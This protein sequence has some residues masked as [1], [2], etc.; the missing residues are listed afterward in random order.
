MQVFVALLQKGGDLCK[1]LQHHLRKDCDLCK[2][3]QHDLRKD[4]DLCKY[5]QHDLRKD[6]DLCKYLQHDLRKDGDL[7]KYLQHDLR[8]DGDLCNY[9]QHDFQKSVQHTTCSS[10]SKRPRMHFNQLRMGS[11]TLLQ[12][13][14][15][16]ESDP[17]FP[18]KKFPLGQQRRKKNI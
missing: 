17:N 4:C 6:G 16:W 3:L 10:A 15:L 12:M 7:C 11:V 18:Q 1:Y 13:A 14:F 5:L 9:L 2:Y 8:K